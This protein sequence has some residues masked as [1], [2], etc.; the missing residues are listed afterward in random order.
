[1]YLIPLLYNCITG[2][3][4]PNSALQGIILVYYSILISLFQFCITGY[5]FTVFCRRDIFIPV[6]VAI[7]GLS[8]TLQ[9]V[10]ISSLSPPYLHPLRQLNNTKTQI[11]KYTNTQI[12]LPASFQL[13]SWIEEHKWTYV[14]WCVFD[15]LLLAAKDSKYHSC[16][17]GWLISF[18][19]INLWCPLGWILWWGKLRISNFPSSPGLHDSIHQ[20][21]DCPATSTPPYASNQI[22]LTLQ[23]NICKFA[24]TF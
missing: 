21:G 19:R 4:Y 8:G 7:P 3:L 9:S 20:R 2:Y 5:L 23:L 12:Q 16:T 13:F 18:N 14:L 22:S 15:T 10:T 24:T 1:M 6:F 17:F 11:H